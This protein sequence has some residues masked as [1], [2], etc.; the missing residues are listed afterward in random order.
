MQE[1][2]ANDMTPILEIILQSLTVRERLR[3]HHL[4]SSFEREIPTSETTQSGA[5]Q[6]LRAAITH[7]DDSNE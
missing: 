6:S 7:V 3:P 5:F 2:M 1:M 4:F